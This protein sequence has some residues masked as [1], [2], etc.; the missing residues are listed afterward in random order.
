M[1]AKSPKKEGNTK[2][3]WERLHEWFLLHAIQYN[4]WK[5]IGRTVFP[6]SMPHY[7]TRREVCKCTCCWSQEE[8]L[9]GSVSKSDCR[10]L[11]I[12]IWILQVFNAADWAGLEISM[13]RCRQHHASQRILDALKFEDLRRLQQSSWYNWDETKQEAFLKLYLA[14]SADDRAK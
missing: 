8:L 4:T 7:T 3:S 12:I 5:Q 9:I 2:E 14:W 1:V 6:T 10:P 11:Y 13:R